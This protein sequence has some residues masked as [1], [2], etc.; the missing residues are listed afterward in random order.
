MN[1][2]RFPIW[3]TFTSLFFAFFAM[4]SNVTFAQKAEELEEPIH[5][6]R[7]I[8]HILAS[9]ILVLSCLAIHI[10]SGILL[11]LYIMTSGI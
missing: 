7:T 5:R 2:D 10:I 9:S 11:L 1:T 3:L 6:E 4:F 8:G